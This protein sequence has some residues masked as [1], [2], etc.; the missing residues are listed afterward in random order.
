MKEIGQGKLIVF[1]GACDG[2]GKT[3]Q[4]ERLKEHLINDGEKIIQ[5]HFPTYEAYHGRPVKRYLAGKYG[6]PSE[7]SPYFVNSLYAV[8]R[9]VAWY[10]KLQ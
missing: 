6:K 1:E 4:V 10:E 3:T 9:A 2:I 8:D 7:L 5:H